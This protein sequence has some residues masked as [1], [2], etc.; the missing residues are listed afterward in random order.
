MG[1]IACSTPTPCVS[2]SNLD[3]HKQATVQ[4]LLSAKNNK[5]DDLTTSVSDYYSANID[6]IIIIQRWVMHKRL[7]RVLI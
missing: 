1:N 4:D 5:S 7:R 6:K 2:T 3:S